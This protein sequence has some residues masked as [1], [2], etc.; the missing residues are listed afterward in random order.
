MC[1]FVAYVGKEKILMRELLSQPVNSLI[2]QSRSARQAR[3]SVNADGFGVAWYDHDISNIAGIYKSIRPAWNDLNLL[4]LVRMIKS[5]CFVGHVRDATI[6]DVSRVNCHPFFSDQ[7]TFVHNGTIHGFDRL[8][9]HLRKILTDG[10]F[11]LIRG[12]SDSEHFF[13]LLMDHLPQGVGKITVSDLYSALVQSLSRIQSIKLTAGI[14]DITKL[15]CTFTNGKQ[16]VATRYCSSSDVEPVSLYYSKR[17]ASNGQDVTG[18][19]IASEPLNDYASDWD[20]VPLNHALLIDEA[21]ELSI[22]PLTW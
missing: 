17:L 22:K 11:D 13:A 2:H 18:Y 5:T 16:F 15:N 21:L 7:F 3:S 12:N 14:K 6:G 4:H 19:I 20:E 1:R 9:R 8:K 10:S